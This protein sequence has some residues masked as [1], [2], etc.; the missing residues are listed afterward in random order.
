[1]IFGLGLN[2]LATFLTFAFH[3]PIF[4]P[5]SPSNSRSHMTFC[6][7]VSRRVFMV[8]VSSVHNPLFVYAREGTDCST[9]PDLGQASWR[10]SC[11]LLIVLIMIVCGLHCSSRPVRVC[12]PWVLIILTSFLAFVCFL[13][14]TNKTRQEHSILYFCCLKIF[15]LVVWMRDLGS[16]HAGVPAL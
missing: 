7:R 6:V 14:F 4:R 8:F 12:E 9:G 1:M 16:A 2:V 15:Y 13:Y 5:C 3:Q 11:T 10:W